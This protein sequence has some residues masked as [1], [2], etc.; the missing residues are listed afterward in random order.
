MT[1][2]SASTAAN[3][4]QLTPHETPQD[5]STREELDALLHSLSRSEWQILRRDMG[6]SIALRGAYAA[7]LDN[8][9]LV[10]ATD[11]VAEWKRHSTARVY[12]DEEL[13][14]S[15]RDSC[16]ERLLAAN[17]SIRIRI[18]EL[19]EPKEATSLRTCSS[20]CKTYVTTCTP[21]TDTCV[22]H[23]GRW[24]ACFPAAT[25]LYGLT[26]TELEVGDE[27]HL[28]GLTSLKADSCWFRMIDGF[29]L[30]SK[31]K[32]LVLSDCDIPARAFGY[33]PSL[34]HLNIVDCPKVTDKAFDY[35]SNLCS[36]C[37]R[38]DPITMRG[39]S[40]LS[41]LTDLHWDAGGTSQA[42]SAEHLALLPI[43]VT[44]LT[45]HGRCKTSEAALA[46]LS[47]VEHLSLNTA[48]D[49]LSGAFL[50]LLPALQKLTLNECTT[51]DIEL[52]VAALQHFMYKPEGLAEILRWSAVLCDVE[53]EEHDLDTEVLPE[54][55]TA[56]K[57]YRGD[58]QMLVHLCRPLLVNGRNYLAEALAVHLKLAVSH[59]SRER[60]VPLY[61]NKMIPGI[62]KAMEHKA[63]LRPLECEALKLSS[64]GEGTPEGYSNREVM[65]LLL[66]RLSTAYAGTSKVL[67][68]CIS[69]VSS[70]AECKAVLLSREGLKA[71]VKT[72][73]RTR[74][75]ETVAEIAKTLSSA[76]LSREIKYLFWELGGIDALVMQKRAGTVL[77]FF[78]THSPVAARS[79]LDSGRLTEI[80]PWVSS[81]PSFK[82]FEQTLRAIA[83]K[84]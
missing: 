36:L 83:A 69:I 58:L 72:L 1:C 31:L 21:D 78:P 34:E 81:S 80:T 40:K 48:T 2:R 41:K 13:E 65:T 6:I 29:S 76:G 79:F 24:R 39:I 59:Q 84:E 64:L 67:V 5:I 28:A 82:K 35:L 52:L 42:L 15:K 50:K 62:W 3:M 60:A 45:I 77:H 17:D 74:H 66:E 20:T 30:C 32:S 4:S 19:L 53:L 44:H 43:S 14:E 10:V 71:V 70:R 56:I 12:T 46:Q 37:A 27:M 33:M 73:W 18:L 49:N 16:F 38:S 55:S 54:M 47:H 8:E 11:Q 51:N 23:L 9:Q 57:H 26:D 68:E 22:K 7:S 25:S 75:L 63:D 61:A